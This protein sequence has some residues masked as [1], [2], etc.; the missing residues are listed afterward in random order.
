MFNVEISGVGIYAPGEKISNLELKQIAGIEFDAAKTEAKLG[1]KS[2]HI[3]RL[4]GIQETTADFSEKAAKKAILNA[5]LNPSD[6][7]LFIVGTDTP[8]HISPAT[9]LVVQGRVQEG[10]TRGMAFD[11]AASCASFTSAFHV[12]A[13]M[14]HANPTIRHA[15]VVGVYNM[16]AFIKDGDAF[17]LSIFADGAGAIVLSQS[18][19][20]GKYI[21]GQTM[22]DGTQW[23]YI[24]I[25]AGGSKKPITQQVLD[26]KDYGLQ[27]LKPLPGDRNVRLWPMVVNELLSKHNMKVED[28][29]HFIFTQ[30]NKSVIEKVMLALGQPMEKTTCVM[31]EYAYT[32]SACVPMAFGKAIET[33]KV[34]KGDKVLFIAS[35]AGF[36]VAAN[37]FTY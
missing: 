22:V 2:R 18:K 13:S 17:G 24:G 35:G 36:A 34:K 4:R 3:A 33:G 1:I 31:D 25:Y 23:D 6:I 9:A 8:E 10:E 30:I 19:G 15:V 21:G 28:V 37:L 29:D 12:A 16:P 27:N 5:R 7:D 26:A 20:Q 32:G 14:M 11:L